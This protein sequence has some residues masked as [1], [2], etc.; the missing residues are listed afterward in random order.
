MAEYIDRKS[1]KAQSKALLRDAQVP[2][3][4]FFALYLGLIVLLDLADTI[5][6]NVS[7]GGAGLSNPIS[8]FVTVLTG[9]LSLILSAGCFLYCMGVRRGERMEYL[10]LFDGFSFAGK[11]ILLYLEMFLFV[12]LWSLLLVVPGIIALYRYRFAILNL[13]ENPSMGV[14]QALELS[15]RQTYGYKSQLFMLD[16]SY[17]LWILLS[18]LPVFYFNYAAA[19]VA[20]GVYLPGQELSTLVKVVLCDVLFLPLSLLYLPSFRTTELGYFEVAKRTSGTG[21]D[22]AGTDSF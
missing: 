8:L 5:T 19:A 7:G 12:F 14:N 9:L 20:F 11:I 18:S 1:F 17:L 10:T 15:K 16:L 3:L 2:A 4:G 21:N 22:A 13:C 6:D